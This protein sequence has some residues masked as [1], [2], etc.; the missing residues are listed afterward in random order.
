MQWDVT[1]ILIGCRVIC[2]QGQSQWSRSQYCTFHAFIKMYVVIRNLKLQ[3]LRIKV[4]YTYLCICM[5]HA[6]V[7]SL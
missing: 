4:I 3:R 6:P 2:D 7:S 5:L 1:Y